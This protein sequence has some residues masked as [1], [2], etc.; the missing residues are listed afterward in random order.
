M[1]MPLPSEYRTPAHAAPD[2]VG[3][4]HADNANNNLFS[5]LAILTITLSRNK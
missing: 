2:G 3:A 4:A 1:D 5:H